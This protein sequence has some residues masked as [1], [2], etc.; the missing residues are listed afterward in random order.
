M[1]SVF[2]Q[3]RKV[4]DVKVGSVYRRTGPG[5]V[6]ETAKVLGVSPDAAGIPHVRY[7]ISIK[8]PAFTEMEDRRTLNLE[9]FA[10]RFSERIEA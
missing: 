6:V 1:G 7:Q 9:S 3:E 2:R 4:Q 8:R 5:D 10:E